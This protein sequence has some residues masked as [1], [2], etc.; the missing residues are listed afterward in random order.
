[1]GPSV[2][3]GDFRLGNL[4]AVGERITAVIDWEIWSV[5]RPAHR[6]GWFLVNADPRPTR[7]RHPTSTPCRR[8]SWSIYRTRSARVP[9][10]EWFLALAC[11][12][13]TA[14]WALIVKHNR[15]RATPETGSGGRWRAVLPALLPARDGSCCG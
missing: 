7:G 13:S 2:V 8:A 4:L 15:R 3:H 1:M 12:K 9:D 5:G 10:V 6:L 14:T 11:F